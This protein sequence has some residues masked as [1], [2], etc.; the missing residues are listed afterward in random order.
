MLG[1]PCSK[2]G[3]DLP[4]DAPPPP[5]H[6]DCQSDNWTPYR[7]RT[8][9][10]TAQFLYCQ[11][12]MSAP[13]INTLLDLW[14]STLLKHNEPPPFANH[15]DLYNTID[16]T[17]LGDV[18]WQS[19]SLRYNGDEVPEGTVP[20]WMTS[21]YEVWFRDPHTIVKHMIDNPDYNHHVD[22]APV[23]IFNSNGIREYQ[24]FMSGDWAWE[25]AV[26]S[27]FFFILTSLIL[28]EQD[29]ISQEPITHGS[30]LVPIILGSD[31][32]TVSVAT[33]HNEYYPLYMSIGSVHNNIRRA[34][35]GALALIAFLA[36]PKSL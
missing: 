30:M 5:R 24:N 7:N 29:K 28:Q 3:I 23:R 8:E 4:P 13:N 17:P 12:Q 31:K 32:T 25:E 35:R 20:Q 2:D 9:F 11:T 14:A 16:S 34:H 36:I 15:M 1:Q 22:V 27:I 26:S 10:E 19:F 6:T 21:E 18:A 33:G